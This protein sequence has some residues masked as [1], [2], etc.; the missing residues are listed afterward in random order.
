MF[1]QERTFGIEIEFVCKRIDAVQRH[2]D[3]RGL[4]GWHLKTD[5]TVKP[6]AQQQSQN[7]GNTGRE[8]VSPILKGNDGLRQLKLA[9]EAL[10]AAGARVNKSCGL[11]VH[12]GQATW[13]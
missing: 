12:H 9:C 7:F 11:H 2:L 13:E 3:R 1:S 4:T 6:N 5:S 10:E 8:L